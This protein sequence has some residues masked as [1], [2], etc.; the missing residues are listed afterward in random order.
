MFISG[1]A[2]TEN[3]FYCLIVNMLE[4]YYIHTI[5]DFSE[6]GLKQIP[7]NTSCTEK[8]QQ[9]HKPA[10]RT[11]NVPVLFKDILMIKHDYDA[12]KQK[13]EKRIQRKNKKEAYLPCPSFPQ[14]VTRDQIMDLFQELKMLP[15][16]S[17]AVI[18]NLLQGNDCKPVTVKKREDDFAKHAVNVDH[19]YV[20]ENIKDMQLRWKKKLLNVN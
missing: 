13:T 5:L 8:P 7:P 11:S 6:S 12:D 20:P 17:N 10:Q 18:I 9:W 15:K 19:D 14:H 4:H 1:Y 2:N 3:V 16:E